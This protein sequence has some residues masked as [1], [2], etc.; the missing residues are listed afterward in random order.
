MI[1][2]KYH[3][4][5]CGA[6]LKKERTHRLVTPD[7][8]DYYQYHNWGSFP[9]RDYDVYDYRFKC[10]DCGA[11]ITL[12]EQR[13]IKKI[14]KTQGHTVLSSPEIKSNYT[15]HKK[16]SHNRVLLKRI[17]MP[18]VFVGIAFALSCIFSTDKNPKD[19]LSSAIFFLAFA[20][21]LVVGAIRK[22][23]GNYR[24]KFKYAYPYETEAQF[25]KLH[26]YSTHNRKLIA[27]SNKCY[28]FYCKAVLDRSEITDY[29]DNGQTAICP[30]CGIDAIIA[31]SIEETVDEKIIAD[32]HEYWF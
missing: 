25:K 11:R 22:Y 32:M 30:K 19:I 4:A 29:A 8:K 2:N 23:N 12:D 21:I 27:V 10:P 18:I 3:C 13:L 16:R 14:Q 1:F 24:S 7:D 31:D 6:K 17:L 5:K 28:C 20:A 15:T 9:L 26:T